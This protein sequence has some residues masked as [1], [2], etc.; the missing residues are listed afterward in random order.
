MDSNNMDDLKKLWAKQSSTPPDINDLLSKVKELKNTGLRRLII[1]NILLIGTAIFIIFIWYSF[2]PQMVTTKLGIILVILA[3]VAFLFSYNKIIP[4]LFKL[5]AEQS[6]QEYLKNLLEIKAKEQF[7]Y[8]TMISLYFV[9]LSTGICLY[10]IEYVLMMPFW[11]GFLAYAIT[12]TWI[13]FN[14]FYIRPKT[15]QKQEAKLDEIIRKFENVQEQL[16]NE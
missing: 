9:L 6:N 5:N 15:I 3:M 4:F 12:L 16:K 11:A 14:W 8:T 10:M 2:Q 13:G 1:S 7:L